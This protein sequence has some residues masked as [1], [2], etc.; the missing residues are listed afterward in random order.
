MV[1]RARG[2]A[3]RGGADRRIAP[4]ANRVTSRKPS[5]TARLHSFPGGLS[6]AWL[7]IALLAAAGRAPAAPAVGAHVDLAAMPATLQGA[8]LTRLA[9]SGVTGVRMPLDW[10]RVE[11]KPSR[12]TWK[13]DDAAVNAARAKKL[14]VVLIL[15]PNAVWAVDAAWQVPPKERHCSIPKNMKLWERYV[16]QAAVHFKGR[17]RYWQVREQPN[18]RNF[19][20]ARPEYLRLVASAARTVR[21]VDPRASIIVPE[22]GALDIAEIDRL[23]S[24]DLRTSCQVLGVYLRGNGEASKS[25]LAWAV[26]DSE[27]PGVASA[28]KPV[29]VLGADAPILPESWMQQYLL[30]AA[31]HAPRFYLPASALDIGWVRP[32][33]QLRYTG[34]LRLGPAIW[35]LAFEDASGPVVAAWSADETAVPASDLAPI[36][37]AEAVKQAAPVG[38]EPGSSVTVDCDTLG[39]RLTPRPVLVRGL[40]LSQAVHAGPPSR[41]DVLAALPGNAPDPAAPVFVDYS[42]ADSPEHGL[43]NRSLR[44]RVGGRAEEEIHDGRTCLRTRIYTGPREAEL[45]NPW[46]YFDVDDRWLYFGQGK[47]PVAIT[48]ECDGSYLGAERLGFNIWY[49]STTGYRFSPWQWVAAGSGWKRYRVELTDANFSDRNGYDFRINIK[50]SKQDIWISSV[51]VERAAAPIASY[52]AR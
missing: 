5:R 2:E 28:Q 4:S 48:I 1:V 10:N 42:R 7:A 25:A 37:D 32:L 27:V 18:A 14:N 43:Y 36:A 3:Y 47:T 26:L 34:F 40:D 35:A 15:G 41:A 21:S 45:D 9:E 39:L 6:L 31:Y 12:F 23:C 38:G 19:R 29:W 30:S 22:P 16:R 8:E 24:S 20:G 44:T 51:T 13:A 46:L 33:S 50:G 11:P 52:A 17:V 49:D